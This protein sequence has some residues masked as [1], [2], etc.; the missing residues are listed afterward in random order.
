VDSR[1]LYEHEDFEVFKLFGAHCLRRLSCGRRVYIPQAISHLH[2]NV[3]ELDQNGLVLCVS[4]P[5]KKAKSSNVKY[6][7]KSGVSDGE[8]RLPV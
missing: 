3:K 6:F 1:A 7:E 4:K 8:L 2:G 5:Q